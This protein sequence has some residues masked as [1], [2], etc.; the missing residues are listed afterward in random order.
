[1]FAV[2]LCSRI[3]ALAWPQV[4]ASAGVRRE[5]EQLQQRQREDAAALDGRA[6]R[7]ERASAELES[8]LARLERTVISPEGMG[9]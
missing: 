6:L 3:I 4:A 1:M 9:R 7:S 8:R 5:Q 2:A